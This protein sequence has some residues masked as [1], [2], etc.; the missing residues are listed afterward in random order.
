MLSYSPDFPV[1]ETESRYAQNIHT[2]ATKLHDYCVRVL[3]RKT[4]TFLPCVYIYIYNLEAASTIRALRF[5]RFEIPLY[6]K[7]W[8]FAGISNRCRGRGLEMESR[9]MGESPKRSLEDGGKIWGVIQ[10]AEDQPSSLCLANHA[11]QIGRTRQPQ[12]FRGL[13]IIIPPLI[14]KARE[15]TLNF[16][17]HIRW[18]M[19]WTIISYYYYFVRTH[20]LGSFPGS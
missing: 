9:V 6:L 10:W 17:A 12:H 14:S 4:T 13:I 18:R 1:M 8:R 7:R 16:G 19:R 5:A 20:P 15:I 2:H 11:N 3:Q